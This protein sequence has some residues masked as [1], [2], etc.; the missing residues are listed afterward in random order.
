MSEAYRSVVDISTTVKAGLLIRQTHH[1]AA[2]V[3]VAAIV[4]HLLRVFFTGAYRKPRE[5]TYWIGVTMLMTALL[6]G[7]L[8]YSLVDD[9]LSGMGLA[10]GYAVA[11]SI[12]FVGREPRRPDLGRAVPREAGVLRAH[13]HR[14]RVHLPG[15]DRRPARRAPRPRRAQAPHAVPAAGRARPSAGSSGCRSFP[16]QAPRIARAALRRSPASSSCSAASCRSTRSGSGG[17]TTPTSRR[18]APSRTGTSG[19]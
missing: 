5:L 19:G 9:L 13:V 17:R 14:A 16:G 7:Y 6:E 4:L 3:F 15:A 12:P 1:W 10:I 11:L 18:T 2:D 8:G